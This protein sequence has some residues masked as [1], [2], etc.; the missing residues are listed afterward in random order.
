MDTDGPLKVI[1]QGGS[2]RK[3]ESCRESISLL[4]ESLCNPE[5]RGGGNADG[6]GSSAEVSDGSEE[7]VIRQWRKGRPNY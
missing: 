6:K 4:R 3:G 2:K 5:Q 1:L 7:H